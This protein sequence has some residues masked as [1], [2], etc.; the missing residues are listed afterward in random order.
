[1]KAK[2]F[3]IATV[4]TIL[5]ASCA[6]F[7]CTEK[8][9]EEDGFPPLVIALMVAGS[10]G[11]GGVAGWFLN[12]YFDSPETDVQPHLRLAAADNVTDVMSVASVFTAN[13]NTN[14]AQL[15]SMTKEH[16]I[17]QA[18]LEAYT[19][20]SSGKSYDGN[21]VLLGARAYE[22]NSTMT[23][24]AVAQIDSFFDELSGKIADWGTK[25]AYS[26]NMEVG[27]VF[28]NT[29]VMSTG[30]SWNADLISVADASGKTS[31]VYIGTVGENYIVTSDS[32]APAY[33]CNFGGRTTITSEDG[34]TYTLESGKTYLSSLKSNVGNKP[35]QSGI[36]TVTNSV[37]G[38]D[39]L[40]SVMGESYV[41]LKAGLSF[42][43]DGQSR[44]AVLDNG[45]MLFGNGTYNGVSF[46]VVPSNIPSGED[47]PEAVDLT[48]ILKAYQKLLDRIYWTSVSANNSASAVWSI[49]DRAD[50]K[51]YGVTT[52]MASNVYDSAVLSEGMNEILTLSAM[53]QLA[54]YYD[55][56]GD[57]LDDLRIGL[58][59][60]GMDAPF[61]RGSIIDE[62]G[63]KVYDDV[64]FTPFFQSDSVTLER[65]MD[66]SVKQNTLVAVWTDGRDLTTWY[67]D[68]MQTD[69]YETLFIEEGYTLRI[70]QL[71][72]CDDAGMHTEPKVEFK[73]TKVDYVSPGLAKLHKDHDAD[74]G[75]KNWVKGICIVIGAVLAL[76]GLVTRRYILV[77]GGA[78][79]IVFGLFFS[80]YVVNWIAGKVRL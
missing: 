75:T 53:Q 52:L 61:V 16:W 47:A 48:P 46:K 36:Y 39:S 67:A 64:I 68:A 38:G 74:E 1:M 5:C 54:T 24:N 37:I 43:T 70:S 50:Q 17:R 65:G 76:Y 33:V 42:Q 2:V 3:A 73:V 21:S 7:A 6:G 58:Y 78:A 44:Y 72:I 66:H 25:D 77:I 15:W 60:K 35:F 41:P 34:T 26:G 40:S 11:A 80:D 69:G 30:C 45:K 29:A 18:E 62:F 8:Q 9:E 71:G 19:E 23:A 22:N 32:Y 20:W 55:A 10:A 27:F 31:E 57:D 56:N 28:D 13:A 12:D 59:G 63:N 49:Y 14:Y 79:L 4:L 51:D